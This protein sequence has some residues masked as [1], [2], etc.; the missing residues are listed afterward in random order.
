LSLP[1]TIK[2]GNGTSKE[3][4]LITRD[5]VNGLLTYSDPYTKYE[6]YSTPALNPE[7]GFEMAINASFSGT[8]DIVHVGTADGTYWTGSNVTGSKANFNS[9]A[10]FYAGTVS[11]LINAP[12]LNN[13]WQFDK[14]ST[15]TPADYLA[16][17][18][19][20][21]V[22]SNW[23]VGDS[24]NLY[25]YDSG[26][27]LQVGTPILL[28][29]YINEF[30]FGTWQQAVIPL[31]DFAFGG[32][33]F[34]TWRMSLVGKNGASPIFYIDN[35]QVEEAGG[36]ET[37]SM[38]PRN[39]ETFLVERVTLNFIDAYAGTLADNSMTNLSYNKILNM[40]K[41]TS[42]IVLNRIQDGVTRFA[43]G[44]TCLADVIKGGGTIGTAFSD[45]TNA[46]LTVDIDFSEPVRLDDKDD[47]S[48]NVIISDNLSGFISF[49]AIARGRII[50][51]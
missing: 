36:L 30:E 19:W 21:Y 23:S 42:G 15:F 1:I 45:G 46:M 22:S 10:Q 51:E 12:A 34:D 41:L 26:S 9:S 3:A 5:S 28:E 48:L 4:Y 18:M 6:Q 24:V 2:D 47:D 50:I 11:V 8:P 32:G 13:V 16:V 7:S 35:F 38:V 39:G 40:T 14:G 49:T 31:A 17:T 44:I 20:V 33:T 29:N 27:A 25:G 37:F 43:S